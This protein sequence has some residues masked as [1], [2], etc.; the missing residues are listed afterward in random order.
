[1]F[2]ALQADRLMLAMK[3]QLLLLR[4]FG[5]SSPPDLLW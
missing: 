2:F 1:L 3:S 4:A 5:F